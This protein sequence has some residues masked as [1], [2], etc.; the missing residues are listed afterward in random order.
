ML[1]DEHR[2]HTNSSEI[3]DNV[4]HLRW[5]D[6]LAMVPA[7]KDAPLGKQDLHHL[8]EQNNFAFCLRDVVLDLVKEAG[9]S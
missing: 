5:L 2:I 9:E 7:V 6:A 4:R 8:L 1:H 3:A